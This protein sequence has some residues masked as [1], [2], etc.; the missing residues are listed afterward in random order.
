VIDFGLAFYS[1]DKDLRALD[2]A[3]ALITLYDAM[4]LIKANDILPEFRK[5]VSRYSAFV[6]R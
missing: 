6:N 1:D 5:Q 3:F 2:M 4:Y